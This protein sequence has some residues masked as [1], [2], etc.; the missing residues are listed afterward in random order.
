MRVP[1]SWLQDFTPLAADVDDPASLARLSEDFDALGLVVE[2][3]EVVG[4]GL[5]G[6]VVAR[7]LEITAIAGADRIR[8]V[9]V[10]AG[11]GESVEVVCGAWNFVEG[12]IVALATVG[13]TL[14]NGLE[15]ARRKLRGVTSNG[16][17]CSPPELGL[18]GAASGLL[19]LASPG[20]RSP[21]P[22]GVELGR[23][24]AEHLGLVDDAVFDLAIEANRPDA[25]CVAGVARDIAARLRLPFALP[26]VHLEEDPGLDAT[27]L[28]SVRVVDSKACD[29]LAARVLCDLRPMVSPP[30]VAR[31]L[32]L[33]GMRVI[34]AVVDASNYAMLELGQPTHPYDLDRLAKHAIAARFARPG[35]RLVTLDGIEHELGQA[36]DGFRRMQPVDDAVI[37]DGEDRVVGLAGIMGGSSS[38]VRSETAR[39]L[40]EAAHFPASVI[41]SSAKRRNLRSE[42]SARFERGVDPEHTT[43][44]LDRVAQ[45]IVAAARA[46]GLAAPRV[47]S[48]VLEDRPR[49]PTPLRLTLRIAR[50]NGLLGTELSAPRVKALLAPIGFGST[51]TSEGLEVEV[52]SFRPDVLEEADLVEEVARHHGYEA[53]VPRDRRSPKLGRL[54]P[55]QIDRRRLLRLLVGVGAHE[56]WTSSLVDPARE[57]AVGVT[58]PALRLADPIVREESALRTSLVPGLCAALRHNQAHR[59]GE[60]RLFELGAV[61]T[62]PVLGEEWPLEQQELAVVLAAANDDAAST[63]ALWRRIVEGLRIDPEVVALRQGRELEEPRGE[64]HQALPPVLGERGGAQRFLVGLHPTRRGLLIGPAGVLGGLG[65]LDPAIAASFTLGARRI[66]LFVADLDALFALK[67][68]PIL[69]RPVSR[70]P[71]ADVDL[72]FVLPDAVPAEQLE[73]V[74]KKAAGPSCEWVRLVD[75]YRGPALGAGTRSL[76]FRLRWCALDH[77]LEDA[78][79]AALREACIEA[80]ERLLPATLRA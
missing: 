20:V 64:E 40:L 78:E 32:M 30:L 75:V 33:A 57:Q 24:L 28:A 65:E 60:I 22:E 46:S 51:E 47:A 23:P 4:T 26:E 67:R 7:V 55:L 76:A 6:V 45:L 49:R 1:L 31:R 37:V 12:D 29:V 70:F 62:E 34:D 54:S 53:I 27:A 42:A 44:A 13:T 18:P 74:L 79:I 35:E 10:D 38:E 59:N 17:L 66:G 43:R 73:A 21:L 8:R 50:L 58:R 19:V 2:G 14:P 52:P 61:F 9:V 11:A 69:A 39:V 48:G 56:V 5:E 63:M 16:M 71:S 68:R 25:M 15:I 3:V 36:R 80:A 41:G 77:T 72:A